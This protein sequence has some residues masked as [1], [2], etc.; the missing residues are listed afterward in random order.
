MMK[1]YYYYLFLFFILPGVC[2]AAPAAD[3][4]APEASSPVTFSC[5]YRMPVNR[6]ILISSGH[7]L[8]VELGINPLAFFS[9]NRLLGIYCGM[10]MKDRLWNTAFDR[11]FVTDYTGSTEDINH[12]SI[13]SSIIS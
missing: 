3:P 12:T 8:S 6:N 7:G 10:G 1:H 4:K 13:D 2:A 5:S 9:G 11:D